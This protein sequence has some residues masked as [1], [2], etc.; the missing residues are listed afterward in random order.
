M[1]PQARRP[2]RRPGSSAHGRRSP[3]RAGRRGRRRLRRR[4]RPVTVRD[5]GARTRI[6]FELD[7]T[8]VVVAGAGTGKTTALVDRIVELVRSGVA[9]LREIAAITFTEAAAAELRQRVREKIEEVAAE[10]PDESR[11]VTAR[12][13]VDEA[14]VSTL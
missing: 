11:L 3:E 10:H 12:Q 1:G 2:R 6:R 7:S 8:L 4:V 5:D 9:S 13:E 14:A